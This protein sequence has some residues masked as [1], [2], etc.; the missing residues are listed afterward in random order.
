MKR[1]FFVIT[2]L[3]A[4]LI[5]CTSCTK[6]NVTPAPCEGGVCTAPTTSVIVPP[7]PTT[8]PVT[9]QLVTGDS[10]EVTVPAGWAQRELPEGTHGVD[11]VYVSPDKNSLVA[12]L[13][14]PFPGTSDE[15]VLEA[16]RGLKGAGATLTSSTQ[17]ELNDN[18]FVLIDSERD[19]IRMWLWV[20]ARNGFGL[21]LSCGGTTANEA[22]CLKVSSSLKLK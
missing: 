22:V 17:V 12:M 2:L 19:G 15:Y 18:K 8:P 7:V 9:D 21:A 10:Y 4:G 5:S 3:A 14:E 13:N 20:T 1:L 16:I 11:W 6:T